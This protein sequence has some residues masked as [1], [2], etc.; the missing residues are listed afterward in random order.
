M[1]M[2]EISSDG[3]VSTVSIGQRGRERDCGGDEVAD[4]Y[5]TTFFFLRGLR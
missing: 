4:L 2:K 5:F 1:F 3:D